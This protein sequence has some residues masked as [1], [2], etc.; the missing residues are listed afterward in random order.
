VRKYKF[1]AASLIISIGNIVYLI[2]LN[3]KLAQQYLAS[4]GKTRAL[5]GLNELGWL[6][7]KFYLAPFLIISL[8]LWIVS[9]RKKEWKQLSIVAAILSIV[10]ILLLLIRFWRWM[11]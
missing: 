3:Y 6:E 8:I 5:F 9:F 2:V 4:S 1:A 10:S 11:V 7:Y